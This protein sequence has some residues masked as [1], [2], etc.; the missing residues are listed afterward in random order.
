ML[1]GRYNQ[2]AP[3]TSAGNLAIIRYWLSSY[4]LIIAFILKEKDFLILIFCSFGFPFWKGENR[5]Y[6]FLRII[7]K[8]S[9]FS[10][11]C[12]RSEKPIFAIASSRWTNY[13]HI[14]MKIWDS[15]HT[16]AS[17]GRFGKCRVG[18]LLISFF[19]Y[20]PFLLLKWHPGPW[21]RLNSNEPLSSER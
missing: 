14:W 15:A 18:F 16:C 12:K 17:L 8:F 11:F 10:S 3:V 13:T 19:V 7:T 21:S 20:P 2:R 5:M 4:V 1:S 6:M 9:F